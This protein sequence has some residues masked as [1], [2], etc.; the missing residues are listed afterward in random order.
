VV[1]VDKNQL[2]DREY[3]PIA[4]GSEEQRVTTWLGLGDNILDAY[5]GSNCRLCRNNL[6]A[7][8]VRI[9][10]LTFDA[11]ELPEPELVVPAIAD[12][13]ANFGLWE[14]SDAAGAIGVAAKPHD[15]ALYSRPKAQL[16]PVK[17]HFERLLPH[18]KFTESFVHRLNALSARRDQA[19]P[20]FE[21]LAR[22]DAAV[23]PRR[24]AQYPGFDSMFSAFLEVVGA[25]V[26]EV[27][28][29]DTG[30]AI[31]RAIEFENILVFSLGAVTG[32][33]L[34][35]LLV[36]IQ[37]AWKGTHNRQVH[38]VGLHSRTSSQR[39]WEAICHSYEERLGAV[40][41]SYLPW[42]SPLEEEHLLLE[43][44]GG[45][46]GKSDEVTA[47]MNERRAYCNPIGRL[48]DWTDRARQ[49]A[50]GHFPD[51]EG[52]L[53]GMPPRGGQERV[54][55]QSVYGYQLSALAAY[56]AVG[57]AV[58]RRRTTKQVS[59][60]QRMMFEI[61]AI[62]RSYYDAVIIASVLRW[63]EPQE[64]WWGSKDSEAAN[65]IN[66]ILGRTTDQ[67]ELHVLI[68]ELLLAGAQGKM[69]T[70][71]MRALYHQ[72]EPLTSGWSQFERAPVDLGMELLVS[73][74]IAPLD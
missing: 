38:G 11:I 47:F 33:T 57:S 22:C 16:M 18:P 10:P 19:F 60:P 14:A 52:V 21:D 32:W 50:E 53:W 30:S 61:P 20:A 24:D 67:T 34:R 49:H 54:R 41:L 58:H 68:P 72:V 73:S 59:V 36:A 29:V 56:T 35:Q 25:N 9:D 5:D 7:Q 2:T 42:R 4:H 28:Q 15:S 63:L 13:M 31:E 26:T 17:L 71:A 66:E 8:L 48:Q 1:L 44:L 6:R 37:D 45:Q 64:A 12:G 40:W 69:P 51:P 3:T 74:S 70:A 27:I 65:T 62:V 46:L 39:E 55:N 43:E 23:V